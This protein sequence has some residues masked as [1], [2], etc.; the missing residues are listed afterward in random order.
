MT[1]PRIPISNAAA[2]RLNFLVG[3]DVDGHWLA[4]ESHGLAGGIFKS[5]EEA[6][7]YAMAET[8]HHVEAVHIV[9]QPL[10]FHA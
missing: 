7:R 2:R 10:H 1:I 3:Q 6:L 8:A 9:D 4:L 5:R